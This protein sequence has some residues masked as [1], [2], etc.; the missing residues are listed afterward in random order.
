MRLS[1][2]CLLLGAIVVSPVVLGYS[3]DVDRV[4][5]GGV[6][7]CDTCHSSGNDFIGPYNAA[8]R[9]WTAALA[10]LDSDGDGY[11]N[12]VEL[13]DP[14]GSW[15][16]GQAD[17]GDSDLVTNPGESSSHP[18]PA[19]ATPTPVVST[20][21]PEP[22]ATGAAPTNTPSGSDPTPTPAGCSGTGVRI[23]MP[24]ASFAPG[25]TCACVAFVCN[26]DSS[27]ISG[28]PLFVILDIVGSYYFAPGFSSFEY[29]SMTFGPGETEVTVLP[30][31]MWPAGAGSF[32]GAKWYGALTDPEITG[33]IGT[34]GMFEFG[35]TE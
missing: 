21:T 32:T 13:Q 2:F 8:G 34:L 7:S 18:S 22:T 15:S 4:P 28:N 14:G 9:Q 29:Y 26:G 10:A 27:S 19:T 16:Q 1:S 31:F 24:A 3:Q 33:L 30:E 20:P 23:E 25:D 35:W 6:F 5:N 11:S 17:P 12:G